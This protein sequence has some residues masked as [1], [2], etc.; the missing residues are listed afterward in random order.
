MLN[1]LFSTIKRGFKKIGK[2]GYTLIEVTAVVAITSTLAA[3]VIPVAVDK[4]RDG[5]KA[6]A[7]EEC[8]YIGTAILAFYKDSG[9]WP[10]RKGASANFY[11]FLRSG[12]QS[13]D[14]FGATNDPISGIAL[15]TGYTTDD[16]I[17]LLQNHLVLDKPGTV[18]N[19]YKTKKVNWKGPYV[20][21]L[22]G[23]RDPWGNNYIVYVKPMYTPDVSS[24]PPYGWVLSAGPN[25]KLETNITDG[26]PKGD[27]IGFMT[28][29]DHGKPQ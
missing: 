20:T 3:V 25:N 5:K 19:D 17:D 2:C 23:K 9:E 16:D 8:K 7:L 21:D 29:S 10:A 6:G 26:S 28:A 18:V 24:A 11:Q 1:R 4:M 13:G 27:D 14:L 22:A 15:P 12:E